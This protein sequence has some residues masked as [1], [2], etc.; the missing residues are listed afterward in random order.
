M[1]KSVL[2]TG[3][4]S[5]IGF[6]TAKLFKENGYF[7]TITGRNSQRVKEAAEELGVSSLV[8]DMGTPDDLK[9]IASGFI[10]T[11]LD[12]LVNNAAIAKFMPLSMCNLEDYN[13]FFTINIRGPLLLTQELLTALEQKRGVVVNVSSAVVNNGL[14]NAALYAASKGAMDAYTKSLAVEL[15]PLGIRVNAVSPGATDT[16]I[17][18]KLGLPDA[19]LPEIKKQQ[20]ALIPLKRWGK[21]EEIAQVIVAQAEATYVTGSIWNVDGGVN[22]T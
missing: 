6:A 13:S 19:L 5:G 7:V 9:Q 11:G 17:I 10:E 3:G 8:G 21:P 14:S 12:V 18:Q 22:A 1:K 4:N 16:P 15:A 2:I 20:E